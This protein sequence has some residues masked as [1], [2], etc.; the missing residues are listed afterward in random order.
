VNGWIYLEGQG[1]SSLKLLSIRDNLFM[2]MGAY[3][4]DL[5]YMK[6][7]MF[8]VRLHFLDKLCVCMSSVI[9]LL[10]ST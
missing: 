5:C 4:Q 6:G 10:Y 8:I 9:C 3:M 7:G 2:F 1:F